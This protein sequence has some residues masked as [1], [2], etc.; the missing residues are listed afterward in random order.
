MARRKHTVGRR[1]DAAAAVAAAA[2]GM[3]ASLAVAASLAR[4]T[5]EIFE[6]QGS[7]LASPSQG[8]VVRTEGN[9]VTA[10]GREG[11]FIQTPA[12]RDDG[13]P[14]TSN[15]LYVVTEVSPEVEVGQLV[16][17]VGTVVELFGW[18]Q[19]H[20][21]AIV[22]RGSGSPLPAPVALD[23]RTPTSNQPWPAVE[24]ERFE[25]MR[26]RIASGTVAAPSDGFGDARVVATLG[27]AFREPGILYPGLPGLPVFDGN[28]EVF[29]L[30]PGGLTG[31]GTALAGGSGF[32]AVGVLAEEFNEYRLW[33]TELELAAAPSLPQPVRSRRAG[34]LTVATQNLER[35][36]RADSDPP[37][38][39]RLGK[40][41]RQIRSVLRAPDVVAVQEVKDLATLSDLASR[42]RADDPAIVYA[43]RHQE[44]PV[45][46]QLDVGFL[47]RNTV[48]IV[49]VTQIGANAI[50]SFDGSLLNDRPPLVL[51][52][53]WR[54]H[55]PPL[56]LTVV[57]VHQRS[58][59]GIDD[60]QDGE[61]VRRKRHEQ[62]VWLAGW[63]QQRQ[64]ERP[65]ERLI[66]VG[67]FNAFEFTDGYVD[68]MG[69]V[70]GRPDPRGALIP[71]V[72]LLDPPLTDW[73]ASL[74]AAERYS[75]VWD[76]NAELLDH[77][78]TTRAAD[79]WVAT[80][81]LGRGNADA[82]Q[83]LEDDPSTAARSSD[84]DGLVLYL[85]PH[86]RRPE[87]RMP[88]P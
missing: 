36:D 49:S 59:I 63:I 54:G 24:L 71:A 23:R 50:F 58:L 67:D 26:L 2:L 33:P 15:G 14:D 7:G 68:V 32:T 57:A 4:E 72:P 79:P 31:Q 46:D 66:V 11:F 8:A 74:P 77:V 65:D 62:A 85:G 25:G 69:Q 51:E 52:A 37:F 87:G 56:P 20:Q 47:V 34:E 17:V 28:P 18:T 38:A 70:T 9:V 45:V 1:F 76:G 75:Y 78:L 81:A 44:A 13:N 6:I 35:L 60:P 43:A 88:L 12:S 39:T 41:S 53:S 27:R 61:R 40:L 30:A 82:P 86:V 29:W 5:L 84:H 64:G 83:A 19:L 42:I 16:D 80:V 48:D 22:V 21:P 10:V 55:D 73:V 3:L